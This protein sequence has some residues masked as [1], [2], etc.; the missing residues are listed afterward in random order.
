MRLDQQVKRSDCG[1]AISDLVGERRQ[2]DL[3]AFA[4]VAL[5]LAIKR[6]VRPEL[7]EHDHGEQARPEQPAQGGVERGWGLRHLARTAGEPI[8]ETF[9]CMV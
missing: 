6:L 8:R 2:A 4:G 1:R 7:L 3:Y 5:A 9:T